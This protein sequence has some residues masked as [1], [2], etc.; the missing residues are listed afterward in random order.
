LNIAVSLKPRWT[1]QVRS[2]V[3]ARIGKG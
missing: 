3:N 2:C 1:R